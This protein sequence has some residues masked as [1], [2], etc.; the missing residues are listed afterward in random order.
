MKRTE[1]IQL[2]GDEPLFTS[3]M[4]LSPGVDV[5]DVRKQL[6]RWTRDGTVIQLRRGL[7]A[8]GATYRRSEPHL[9][10]LSNALVA[11]SYVSLEA[12]L[13][14]HGL[15]PE[16]V[17]VTT[18]V[19]TGKPVRRETPFGTLVYQHIK[20]ELF[21]GYESVAVSP[22]RLVGSE[23]PRGSRAPARSGRTAYVAT[24][25]KA[26]LD[27]AHLTPGADRPPFVRELRL[28]GLD[29]IDVERLRAFAGRAGSPKLE[30]FAR[31]VAVLAASQAEEYR[32]P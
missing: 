15:I 17:F 5:G 27:L 10:E 11:G 4:L 30:R 24:P 20:K 12:A 22:E 28:Q 9:F 26:L 18:A 2:V 29:A 25:E 19:T 13:A 31:H 16:A 32:T 23:R 14:Y 1:L 7:Y 6:S 21:W 3:G 8:L